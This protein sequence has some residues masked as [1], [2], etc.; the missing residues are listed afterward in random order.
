MDSD[1]DFFLQ[2][3]AET[4]APEGMLRCKF[5]FAVVQPAHELHDEALLEDD[6]D[7]GGVGNR[8]ADT[9]DDVGGGDV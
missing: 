8:G 3:T 9:H 6:G 7:E 2:E 1:P 5:D 4:V